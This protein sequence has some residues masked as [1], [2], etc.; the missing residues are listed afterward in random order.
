MRKHKTCIGGKRSAIPLEKVNI[1]AA[2]F[3]KLEINLHITVEEFR[4]TRLCLFELSHF[5]KLLSKHCSF[6][7]M[8]PHFNRTLLGHFQDLDFAS[9]QPFRGGPAHGVTIRHSPLDFMV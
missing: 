3:L 1:L 4:P 2:S 5:G 6:K 7:V 8:P 9:F